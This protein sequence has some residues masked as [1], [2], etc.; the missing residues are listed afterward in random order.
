MATLDWDAPIQILCLCRLCR[1]L[2][3]L[4]E[5]LEIK[6]HKRCS[7]CPWRKTKSKFNQAHIEAFIKEYFVTIKA[8]A[9]I[10]ISILTASAD[11]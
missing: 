11:H 1:A 4:K 9:C 5:V 7:K 8:A 10:Y 2:W 3:F 6:Q